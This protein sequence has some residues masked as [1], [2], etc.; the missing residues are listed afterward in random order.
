MKCT[1]W[2]FGS[3]SDGEGGNKKLCFGSHWRYRFD[4]PTPA[5]DH[6]PAARS[7]H[8][9]CLAPLNFEDGVGS[10]TVRNDCRSDPSGQAVDGA[11]MLLRTL[12]A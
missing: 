9:S 10:R 5:A 3:Q 4:E 7:I 12:R 2:F 6:E 1:R 11:L 8:E